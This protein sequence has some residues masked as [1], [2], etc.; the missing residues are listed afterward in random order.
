[1]RFSRHLRNLALVVMVVGAVVAPLSASAKSSTPGIKLKETSGPPVHPGPYQGGGFR[2]V[3]DCR[4]IVR[5]HRG[6]RCHYGSPRRV[7]I[8]V[9]GARIGTPRRPHGRSNGGGERPDRSG[10]LPR[11]D[12]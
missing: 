7:L 3:G 11:S 8:F 12:E 4:H 1:M 2:T 10:N 5:L 6:G 9:R